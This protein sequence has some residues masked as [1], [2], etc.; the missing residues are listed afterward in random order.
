ME[1]K[2][3]ERLTYTT[4]A[5]AINPRNFRKASEMKKIIRHVSLPSRRNY[6]L[7]LYTVKGSS[8]SSSN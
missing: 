1:V 4:L 2:I 7:K 6:L 8:K 5:Q 3:S